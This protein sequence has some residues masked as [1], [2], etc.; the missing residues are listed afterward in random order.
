MDLPRRNCLA[1]HVS[2]VLRDATDR[3]LEKDGKSFSLAQAREVYLPAFI[4]NPMLVVD[5]KISR[6]L[7]F[8]Y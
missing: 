7:H 8:E 5:V 4:G 2:Q 3:D 1:W 6:H